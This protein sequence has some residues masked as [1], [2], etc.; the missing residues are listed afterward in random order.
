M[1]GRRG[2]L[3]DFHLNARRTDSGFVTEPCSHITRTTAEP[4]VPHNFG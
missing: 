1:S 3:A 4:T 2:G